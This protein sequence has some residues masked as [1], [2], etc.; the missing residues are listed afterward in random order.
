[1]NNSSC[2]FKDRVH[3]RGIKCHFAIQRDQILIHRKLMMWNIVH[4]FHQSDVH[5]DILWNKLLIGKNNC[6][7]STHYAFCKFWSFLWHQT[8]NHSSCFANHQ[9]PNHHEPMII[10]QVLK[11]ILKNKLSPVWPILNKINVYSIFQCVFDRFRRSFSVYWSEL[12]IRMDS[13][14]SSFKTFSRFNDDKNSLLA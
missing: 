10:R 14:N 1:M 6:C 3:A 2:L 13:I 11:W 8:S 9:P 12:I 4:N 5:N 7:N